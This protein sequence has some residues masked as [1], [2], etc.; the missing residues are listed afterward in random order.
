MYAEQ[1]HFK[2]DKRVNAKKDLEDGVYHSADIYTL[3]ARPVAGEEKRK[4]E[5][6]MRWVL[7]GGEEHWKDSQAI[8]QE[9]LVKQKLEDAQ[10]RMQ[11]KKTA[12]RKNKKAHFDT[13]KDRRFTEARRARSKTDTT[14]PGLEDILIEASNNSD[15]EAEDTEMM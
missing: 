4:L 8:G 15:G 9:T 10:L 5:N 12:K 2:H 7:S 13:R 14:K 1:L 3:S 11:G 6:R